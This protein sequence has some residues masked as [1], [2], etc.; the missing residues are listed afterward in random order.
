MAKILVT[1]GAGYIGSILVPELLSVG[2]EV[3]VIDNFL[4]G[5]ASLLDVCR[6]DGFRMIY[7]DARDR[8]L[9]TQ[10][11]KDKDYIIPLACIVGA[12]ACERDPE[13]YRYGHQ[14]ARS[15]KGLRLDP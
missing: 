9:L 5:Q 4:Y 7:G 1:G 2:Y 13:R 8:K 12:P 15:K 6:Y 10:H 14:R 3:T 11:I